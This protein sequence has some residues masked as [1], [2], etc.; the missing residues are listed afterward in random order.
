M[1]TEVHFNAPVKTCETCVFQESDFMLGKR[2]G[3]SG[4]FC[5]IE[6][7]YAAHP[8]NQCDVNFSG[9]RPKPPRRSLRR[10]LFDLFLR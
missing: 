8:G 9:W 3:R 7:M 4:H 10:W 5:S 6:R 2:C 1:K